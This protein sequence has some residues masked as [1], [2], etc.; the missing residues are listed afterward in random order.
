MKTSHKSGDNYIITQKTERHSIDLQTFVYVISQ[1]F[2]VASTAYEQ[3]IFLF[4]SF[5][6]DYYVFGRLL[7]LNDIK[8]H[9][10]RL[11]LIYM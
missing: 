6:W 3:V 1:H 11:F 4:I 10:F 5:F 7:S 8:M 9:K 2:N